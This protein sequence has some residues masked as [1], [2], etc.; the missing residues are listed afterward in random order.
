MDD[1][2]SFKDELD[3]KLDTD[4]K[5]TYTSAGNAYRP[6]L[7]L[8]SGARVIRAWPEKAETDLRTQGQDHVG[9]ETTHRHQTCWR[10]FGGEAAIDSLRCSARV[11][12]FS[13]RGE[14]Y[15]SKP[16]KRF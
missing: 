9:T 15:G 10:L 4:M 7:A 12:L 3:R 14:L 16:V 5:R 13:W 11:M 1:A 8:T 2:V 6:V